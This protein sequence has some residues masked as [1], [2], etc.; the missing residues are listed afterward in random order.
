MLRAWLLHGLKHALAFFAD[1]IITTTKR[2]K[3]AY[4]SYI[5]SKIYL[6]PNGVD[7]QLF[8]PSVGKRTRKKATVIYVGRLET[9]KNPELILNSIVRLP[10]NERQL[11]IIGSGTLTNALL[12]LAR[13]FQIKLT[14]YPIIPHH[15][16]PLYYNQARIFILVSKF[17]GHPKALLEAMSCS[18]PVVGTD[19]E[20]INDVI[21]HNYNGL[22]LSEAADAIGQT[23]KL[24][25]RNKQLAV[26]LGSNA[27]RTIVEKYNSRITWKKE[28]R[29][30]KNII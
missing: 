25:L 27:R 14:H 15:Q 24:L 5:Q 13:K 16:L 3:H 21:T 18:L 17:E 30:L 20:G 8:K 11:L 28:I 9:Q 19:V 23:L 10:K 12:H 4:P 29:L 22:L 6:I 2:L 7:V 26:K 1:A